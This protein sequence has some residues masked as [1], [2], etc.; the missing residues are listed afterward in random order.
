V[1]GRP[2]ANGWKF[3]ER[4][5]LATQIQALVASASSEKSD[6]FSQLPLIQP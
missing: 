3:T 1:V 6:T 5:D 2:A 4:N